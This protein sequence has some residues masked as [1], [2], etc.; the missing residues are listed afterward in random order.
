MPFVILLLL[1]IL[2]AQFGFWDTLQAILGS[3]A[4]MAVLLSLLAALAYLGFR[5]ILRRAGR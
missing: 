3:L 2:I 1:V 4:M 5:W